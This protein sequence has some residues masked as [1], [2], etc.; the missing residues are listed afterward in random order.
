MS[1]DKH[2]RRDIDKHIDTDESHPPISDLSQ[3]GEW[4]CELD[5][6]CGFLTSGEERG[7]LVGYTFNARD[8]YR[9]SYRLTQNTGNF[10]AMNRSREPARCHKT[11]LSPN[12]RAA[13]MRSVSLYCRVMSCVRH[14]KQYGYYRSSRELY[15]FGP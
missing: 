2:W 6:D 14:V 5:S 11:T 10:L 9:I 3:V 15:N 4:Q 1:S 7:W 13:H 12:Y 8:K